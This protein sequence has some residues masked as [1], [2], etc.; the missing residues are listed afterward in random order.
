MYTARQT[1]HNDGDVRFDKYVMLLKNAKKQA[2]SYS[3]FMPSFSVL[4]EPT[5]SIINLTL[6]M[7]SKRWK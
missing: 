1:T 5:D 7:T 4:Q 2:T 3:I 6:E